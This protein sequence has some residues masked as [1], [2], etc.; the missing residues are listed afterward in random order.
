MR[1]ERSGGFILKSGSP[2]ASSSSVNARCWGVVNR[3]ADAAGSGS[4][5]EFERLLAGGAGRGLRRPST[6]RGQVTGNDD[7]LRRRRPTTD[8][9]TA[10]TGP[11]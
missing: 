1:A 5:H 10:N 11:S 4:S 6:L 2:P 9:E 8:A 3:D 7:R